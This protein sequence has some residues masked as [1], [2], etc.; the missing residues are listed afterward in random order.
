MENTVQHS[1]DRTLGILVHILGLFTSWIGPLIVYLVSKD[2]MTK[3]NARESLNFQITVMLAYFL[4]MVL[5]LVL[6]GI[7]MMWIVFIADLVLCIVAAV[8][9][10]NGE[11]Y[12][13]PMTLR[14]I[15]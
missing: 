13:Y 5:A 12:R 3:D 7:F 4:C 8:K 1:E 14:L 11:S 10:S 15:K 2:G 9:T 6:I